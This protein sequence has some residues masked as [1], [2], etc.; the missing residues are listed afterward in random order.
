MNNRNSTPAWWKFWRDDSGTLG[1]CLFITVCGA[2]VSA[3][4]YG[5]EQWK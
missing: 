1:L 5:L 3:V 2:A 4:L